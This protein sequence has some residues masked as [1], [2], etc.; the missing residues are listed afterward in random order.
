MLEIDL[1][2]YLIDIASDSN[3]KSNSNIYI[4][5][6]HI[7]YFVFFPKKPQ[8]QSLSLLFFAFSKPYQVNVGLH[9]VQ[10]MS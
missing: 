7:K 9:L 6:T 8:D 2:T 1:C 5:Q 10:F 3:S 4:S